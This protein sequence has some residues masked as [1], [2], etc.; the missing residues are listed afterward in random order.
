MVSSHPSG[1]V[2]QELIDSSYSSYFYS[3]EIINDDA[4]IIY[5]PDGVESSS[6]PL[7]ETIIEVGLGSNV[8][9]SNLC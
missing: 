3:P 2:G 6:S 1:E 4:T 7:S 8:Y 9:K 5:N